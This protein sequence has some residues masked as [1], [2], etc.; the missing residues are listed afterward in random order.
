MLPQI[1]HLQEN[2]TEEDGEISKIQ[3]FN[4]IAQS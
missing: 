2:N 4:E 1:R 3:D